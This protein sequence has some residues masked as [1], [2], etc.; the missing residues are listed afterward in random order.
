MFDSH[1]ST[2]TEEATMT[3]TN[4]VKRQRRPRLDERL[5]AFVKAFR[6]YEAAAQTPAAVPE[7]LLGS[8]YMPLSEAVQYLGTTTRQQLKAERS[9][10]AWVPVLKGNKVPVSEVC[11]TYR[12]LAKQR[13]LTLAQAAAEKLNTR[14]GAGEWMVR[15]EAGKSIPT[16]GIVS[17]FCWSVREPFMAFDDDDND[18]IHGIDGYG[19]DVVAAALGVPM[20]EV[21]RL[22]AAGTIFAYRTRRGASLVTRAELD[23][24]KRRLERERAK[25]A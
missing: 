23:A 15:D 9:S 17:G 1:S 2:T 3:T 24:H 7:A 14:H 22:V 12:R 11:R 8:G 10:K 20:A 6:E 16:P 18:G 4:P 5:E 25:A 19:V 21:K 13:L